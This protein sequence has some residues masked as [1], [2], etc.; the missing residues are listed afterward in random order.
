LP[1]RGGCLAP[2]AVA[3]EQSPLR[4]NVRFVGEAHLPEIAAGEAAVPAAESAE[5]LPCRLVLAAKQ[6]LQPPHSAI[7]RPGCGLRAPERTGERRPSPV[8]AGPLA[9]RPLASFT[10]HPLTAAQ[11]ASADSKQGACRQTEGARF[12]LFERRWRERV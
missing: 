2:V 3:R 4:S 1:G 6:A 10:T 5:R 12:R 7:S 9:D 11:N 8:S